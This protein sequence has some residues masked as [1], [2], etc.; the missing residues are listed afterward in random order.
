LNRDA[1]KLTQKIAEIM[2]LMTAADFCDRN[3][4]KIGAR[5][6]LV[7]RKRRLTWL[8]VKQLSDRLALSL[9]RLGLKRD[10]KVLVQ[11]PNCA[12][13]FLTRLACEKAGIRLVTVTPTFRLAE[14]APII[15][16]TRPQAAIIPGHYRGMN[17]LDLLEAARTEELVSVLITGEDVPAGTLAFEEMLSGV[18]RGDGAE[19]LKERRYS[20]LDVCQ[21]ATTSGS[22]GIPKCVE[23]PLYTRLLTGWIHL[24]RFGVSADDKLAA[25][26]S[27]VTGTADALVYNGGCA[28]GATAVLMDHFSPEETCALMAA[29]RVSVIP[30][31]PTMMA[32]ILALPDLS[33]YDLR[34]L[35]LVINHGASLPAA[36]GAEVESRLGC[37]IAQAYGSVDCGGISATRWNDSQEVRL[38][39]LGRP[40]DGNEIRIVDSDGRD[41]APG[42]VGRLWVRGLHSDARFFNNPELDRNRRVKG[43]FDLQELG[44]LDDEGNIVLMGR[45]HDL[46]IRGG[47]NIFPVDV[48]AILS[49]HP[50]IIEVAV[51]GIPDAEMGERV[52]AFLVCGDGK[53]IDLIEI[54]SFLEAKGLAR[55]KWPERMEIVKSLPRVASGYKIDKK[56]LKENIVARAASD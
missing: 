46:I 47:Q 20:I 48:E 27:I 25:V 35:R 12:E 45:E 31:V 8:Q 28:S 15:R 53:P 5:E 16:F 30:L 4:S 17:Y 9:L 36:Q 13:L 34:A 14:L 24:K 7:D 49:Q 3:A 1:Q 42:E 18:A 32:R 50:K 26:T 41:V 2:P 54:K 43:Y 55:F 52:C 23:V 40:L 37:R 39:T 19:E 33:P 11:L 38:G 22:T 6:A 21:I 44:R 10:S 51:V 56:K 29:E